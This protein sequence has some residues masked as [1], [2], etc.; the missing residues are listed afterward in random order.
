MANNFSAKVELDLNEGYKMTCSASGKQII[1]D[2]PKNLGG[3]DL[4]FNPIELL[5]SAL[6]TCK[7]VTAKMLAKKER[8]NLDYINVECSGCFG[9]E[10]RKGLSQIETVFHI[11]S[12]ASDEALRKLIELVDENCPVNNT[13]KNTPE[14]STRLNRM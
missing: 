9:D 14:L 11:K 10:K 3:T 13:L 5:L 12:E 7:C 4:G 8:I 1:A 6:G 2:E